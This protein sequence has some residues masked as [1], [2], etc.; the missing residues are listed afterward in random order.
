MLSEMSQTP[1]SFHLTYMWNQKVESIEAKIRM[2]IARSWGEG[3]MGDA[4]QGYR[5]SVMQDDCS[6]EM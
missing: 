1:I 4:S 3:E 5:V 6:L 2:V